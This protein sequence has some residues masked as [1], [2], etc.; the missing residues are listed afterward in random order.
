[1]KVLAL[2][3]AKSA[4]DEFLYFNICKILRNQDYKI[5]QSV[6]EESTAD[7]DLVLLFD[8]DL[9]DSV[10]EVKEKRNI[11]IILFSWSSNILLTHTARLKLIDHIVMVN[12]KS[13]DHFGTLDMYKTTAILPPF[14][15]NNAN[16]LQ[17]ENN[18]NRKQIY[19]HI[20]P[21]LVDEYPVID[22]IH[23]INRFT[24][25][26]FYIHSKNPNISDILNPNIK[27]V[28]SE[29][30]S[31]HIQ[32]ADVVIGSGY[33]ALHAL[34]LLKP[35]IV[36]GEKGYGG[37]VDAKNIT[38]HYN[39]FFQGRIGGTLLE[40]M[41]SD[42]L[43][44][45]LNQSIAGVVDNNGQDN[46]NA[47]GD[48]VQKNNEKFSKIIASVVNSYNEKKQDIENM[49]LVMNG[50]DLLVM[51]G[52]DKN[53]ILNKHSRQ[54]MGWFSHDEYRLIELFT[55]PKSLNEIGAEDKVLVLEKLDKWMS[56]GILIQ[57]SQ[58]ELIFSLSDEDPADTTNSLCG[59]NSTEEK[60]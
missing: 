22:T 50:F 23:V 8:I 11:P 13:I 30:V 1:M 33:I 44:H 49:K 54:I 36:V 55:E 19:I 17:Q 59:E 57:H 29:A 46:L 15:C 40:H 3:Q 60:F 20:E 41:P 16:A 24:N 52:K 14:Y 25:H 27:V 39:S 53:W 38:Y 18:R 56:Q 12:N 10:V 48:T 31:E 51:S 47:L 32:N 26:D 45:Y 43:H 42:L 5:V 7:I 6:Q 4:S 28:T 35:T 21:Q 9:I 58:K 34:S 2:N 37:V